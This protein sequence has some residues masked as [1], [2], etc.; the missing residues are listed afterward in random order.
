MCDFMVIFQVNVKFLFSVHFYEFLR[1]YYKNWM[2]E[3]T[4]EMICSNAVLSLSPGI[5]K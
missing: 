4:V 1:Y 2:L 3:V 5:V